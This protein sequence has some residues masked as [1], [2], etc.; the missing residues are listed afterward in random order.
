[1]NKYLFI[2]LTI[3]TPGVSN[4]Y[5]QCTNAPANLATSNHTAT[6]VTLTWD[7]MQEAI[8]FGVGITTT[9]PPPQ[10]GSN[11]T[12][13][14]FQVQGLTPGIQYCF[15]VQ[16][17]CSTGKSTWTTLCFTQPC[18]G[19]SPMQIHVDALSPTTAVANWTAFSAATHYEYA[20]TTS[21]TPPAQGTTTTNTSVGLQGLLPDSKYCLHI[22][23]FCSVTQTYTDWQTQCFNTS[24]SNIT[25][26]AEKTFLS[27]YPNPAG[28]ILYLNLARTTSAQN[29]RITDPT[30]RIVYQGVLSGTSESIDIS[31][32]SAGQYFIIVSGAETHEVA[33]FIKAD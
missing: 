26:L 2:A 4:I 19:I 5:A 16:A 31:A 32:L 23:S 1:M 6:T 33:K 18:N 3:F 9:P 20:I 12:S 7:A 11:T 17:L 13:N 30:G 28:N 29:I 21:E 24:A 25:P 14:T 27:A 22:R 15:H 10:N 8:G